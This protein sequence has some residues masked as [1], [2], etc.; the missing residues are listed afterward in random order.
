M[1]TLKLRK[2]GTSIGLL[3]LEEMLVRLQAKEGREVFAVEPPSG[4]TLANLDPRV[5][6]QIE[7]REQ[8]MERH[9][10]VFAALKK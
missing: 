6:K 7:A 2:I 1:F 4:Y 5:Q 8:L 10:D 9:Q 3:L